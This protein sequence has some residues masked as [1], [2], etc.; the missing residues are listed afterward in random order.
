MPTMRS[1][2]QIKIVRQGAIHNWA[3]DWFGL[4]AC[5]LMGTI[6]GRPL[7]RPLCLAA[8]LDSRP[9]SSLTRPCPHKEIQPREASAHPDNPVCVSNASAGTAGLLTGSAK[10]QRATP[11][12]AGPAGNPRLDMESINCGRCFAPCLPKFAFWRIERICFRGEFDCRPIPSRSSNFGGRRQRRRPPKLRSVLPDEL[13]QSLRRYLKDGI[14]KNRRRRHVSDDANRF[15]CPRFA[16]RE[17]RRCRRP[18]RFAGSWLMQTF[19]SKAMRGGP[20]QI[21][22][23]GFVLALQVGWTPPPAPK[24][25]LIDLLRPGKIRA[26]RC[27]RLVA[28]GDADR[29]A[30]KWGGLESKQNGLRSNLVQPRSRETA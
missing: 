26:Q 12:L 20:L 18:R 10:V 6:V 23:T 3:S 1:T 5:C 25:C 4:L 11:R 21:I 29:S 7:G 8:S 27:T 9:M 15:I 24:Q 16:F 30:K 28:S 13:R 14:A 19:S 2:K 22:R 17:D